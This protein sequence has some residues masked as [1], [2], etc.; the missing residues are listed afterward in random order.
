M[1]ARRRARPRHHGQRA[2]RHRDLHVVDRDRGALGAGARDQ[3]RAPAGARLSD[4]PSRRSAALRRGACHHRRDLARP[5]RHGLRQGRAL[6]VPGVEPEPGRRH[7]AVLGIPRLHHQGDDQPRRAVQLGERE[8]PLSPRQSVAAA[9]AGAASSGVEHDRQPHQCA[10]ARR[11]G[12]RDGDAR[13][14]LCDAPAVRCLPDGLRVER[15]P[16]AVRRPLRLSRPR[17]GRD[18]R[19][20][21][22]GCAPNSWRAIC[23]PRRIVAP[24]FRNP[25]G[26]LSIED[27]VRILRG[28]TRQRSKTKDGRFIDMHSRQRPGPDRRR[29]HVLRHARP[30]LRP[31]RR[32]LRILRRHGQPP[33]DGPCRQPVARGHGRQSHAVRQGGAAAAQGTTSS[34]ARRRRRRR[35]AGTSRHAR[36]VAGIH[37]F[38]VA[39]RQARRRWRDKHGH[40]SFHSRRR[41]TNTR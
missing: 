33:H 8:L 39:H 11:E 32:L 23:A 4:R 41:F 27:N 40:D 21:P 26:Y 34:R 28:E 15:P 16:G 37:A 6:R 14:R 29:H 31:D 19:A 35:E 25:P 20:Q 12:L 2:S 1:A 3:A 22:R 24:Q 17:R 10:R 38:L 9:L 18:R 36:A 13:H 5:P 30:G 7:G